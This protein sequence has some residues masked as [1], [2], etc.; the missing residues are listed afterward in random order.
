MK[1]KAI[2]VV[3]VVLILVMS[4]VPMAAAAVYSSDYL[5]THYGEITVSGSGEVEIYYKATGKTTS[6]ELGAKKI[7]LYESENGG[8]WEKVKTFSY[9]SDPKMVVSGRIMQHTVTY[10]GSPNCSY[11]AD[12]SFYAGYN[13]VGEIILHTVFE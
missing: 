4:I 8:A 6:N 11:Y 5:A 9:T 3:S 2:L 13:G 10:N 12:I 1:R 7:V